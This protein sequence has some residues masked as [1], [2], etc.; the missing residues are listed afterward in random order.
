MRP[1]RNPIIPIICFLALIGCAPHVPR[2]SAI[3]LF[4][5]AGTSSGDVAAIESILR[6]QHLDYAT[7]NSREL[8]SVGGREYRTHRLVIVPGGNFI[9]MGNGLT[10]GATSNLQYAVASGLNYLGICAGA[11]LAGDLPRNS[12][13][14]TSGVRF[15]FYSVVNRGIMKAA[16]PITFPTMPARD[17]YWESGPQLSGWGEVVAR[18][19]DGTPAIAQGSVGKGWVVLSGIHPEA[20]ASWRRGMKFETSAADANAYAATL[21]RAALDGTPLPHY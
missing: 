21:I 17:H 8:C 11:F 19:P 18:Y 5:G 14:L 4:T 10:H 13:N 7:A 3:L 6:A 15:P 1:H 9:D 2:P 20:P 16:V 12:I